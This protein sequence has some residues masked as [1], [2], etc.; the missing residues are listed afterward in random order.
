MRDGR[1]GLH[2]GY[3]RAAIW[4]V[5]EDGRLDGVRHAGAWC[6]KPV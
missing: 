2:I 4:Q 6:E 1:D 5:L 3:H